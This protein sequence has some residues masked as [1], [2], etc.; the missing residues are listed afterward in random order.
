MKKS[1]L[2]CMAS[3]MLLAAWISPVMAEFSDVDGNRQYTWAKPSI[4]EMNRRGILT[5]FADG[6]FKPG[7]PVTKAQ[8]TVMVYRL[9]P[10]LRNPDSAAI[11]GVPENHWASREFS[12][13]YSTTWPIY[14][15][16][17]QNFDDESYIYKPEKPMTRWEVLMTL[18]A[19][20]SDMKGLENSALK[21]SAAAKELARVKDIP[22]RQF[23][24]YEEFEKNN[25][26]QSLM[27]PKLALIREG[28]G[29]E[30]A[31]EL[32]YVKAQAL[33][34]FMK[35]GI[36]TPD[37]SGYFYPDRQVT[38]AEIVTIL[39]R[40]L[41]AAGE[42]Y[43]YVKRE[44]ILSG[45]YISP[46]S[47][48]GFGSNLYYSEPESGI[49]LDESPSWSLNPGQRLSKVAIRIESRQ[50]IDLF[51]TINDQTKTYTYEQLGNGTGKISFDVTGLKSFHVRG[52]ARYPEQLKEDGDNEVM[53]YVMDADKEE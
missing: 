44:E 31:G 37:A 1:L 26:A 15:A 29:L 9:F 13:L 43:A 35:L 28:T 12:E 21:A 7:Q 30:W 18:D 48:T 40:M 50:V 4:D 33:Y 34:S 53:I 8:F 52:V 45:A 10:L 46:G 49:V 24:S 42:D 2:I 23:A 27:N 19:L 32:N 5:G 39:N 22:R 41:A 25:K 6:T 14:A 17:V 38:R 3:M 11:S 47:S 16:D 36:I 20:F 51:V